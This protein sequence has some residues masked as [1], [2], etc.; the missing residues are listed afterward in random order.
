MEERRPKRRSRRRLLKI[1]AALAAAGVA[2]LAFLLWPFWQLSA[3]LAARER[4]TPSRLY[5]QPLG[6]AVDQRLTLAEVVAEL[7]ALGYRPWDGQGDLQVGQYRRSGVAVGALLRPHPTTRGWQPRTALEIR[8]RGQ[9]V[10]AV[11]LGGKAVESASLEPPLLKSF[12]GPLREERWPMSLENLPEPLI[13]AVLAVEDDGFFSHQGLS[14]SGIVRAAWV[15]F[16]GGEVRQGGSTLTQQLVKNVF[17]SHERTV[18]RK[19]KEAVL[20]LLVELRYDKPTLLEAYLNEIYLGRRNGLNLIGVGAASRAFFS[21]HPSELDLAESAVIAGLIRAPALYDP[22]RHPEKAL[23]RRNQ[24]LDRIAA[25]GWT[26][27]AQILAARAQELTAGK[28][29]PLPAQTGYFAELIAAEAKRRY[30]VSHLIDGGYH[31]LSTLRRSDQRHAEEAQGWGLKSLEEGW[32]KNHRGSGPLQA[33]LV[34]VDPKNGE[35]LAYLGGRDFK[36]SPFDRAARA[37]RQAGSAFKPVIYGA[38]F[39]A[40]VASP[41]SL[42]EDSPLTVRLAGRS[43]SP[44]N[45]DQHFDGWM[46]VRTALERS[47]NVPTVRMALQVG[48]EDI[49]RMARKMG[50]TT[51]LKPLPSLALGAFEVTPLEM[52]SVYATLA[53]GGLRPPVHGLRGVLGQDGRVLPG[54]ALPAAERVLAPESA[55]L[56]TSVLQGVF[57]RGTARRARQDGLREPLAGKTGTTNDRRDSWFAGFSGDRAAVVWVGYDDNAATRLSGARAALPIW[58]RFMIKVRPPGGFSVVRQPPGIVTASVDPETGE[59]ASDRCPTSITEVFREG[60]EP[61]SA[62]HLHSPFWRPQTA[63][64]RRHGPRKHPFRGWLD[65]VFRGR[66]EAGETG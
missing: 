3:E 43:W 55:Y 59:L 32:Q 61:A 37:R 38:A 63:P 20:A 5:G 47:R 28:P 1:T 15:N 66:R 12:Y 50:I 48:L 18:S 4:P 9:R 8:F 51:P 6:I 23:E 62:C 44:R 64:N 19:V 33:A 42:V 40:R 26:E 57:E 54:S 29:L 21:K 13:Q 7:E 41:S 36:L 11:R 22:I 10:A 60:Q 46:T 35:I 16:R 17:L 53:N 45:S 65:R 34:S 31:L 58:S 27:E 52:A 49:V 30:G 39:E 2:V 56:L 25:L 14:I 24:V